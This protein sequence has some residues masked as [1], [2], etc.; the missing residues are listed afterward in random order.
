VGP[1]GWL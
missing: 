1:Y